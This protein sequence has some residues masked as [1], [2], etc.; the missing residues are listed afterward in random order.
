MS[1]GKEMRFQVST[2]RSGFTAGSHNK[3]GSEFQTVGLATEK[4]RVPNMLRWNRGILRLRPLAAAGN[5]G[6]WHAAVGKVP[7]SSVPKTPMNC[8]A[9]YGQ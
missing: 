5:V 2:K 3:S 8:D 1:D 4:A 7:W 9:R 6:D